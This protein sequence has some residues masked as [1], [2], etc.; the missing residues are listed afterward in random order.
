MLSG[1]FVE[2]SRRTLGQPSAEGFDRSADV[3]HKLR[4]ATHQ[5]LAGADDGQMSLGVYAPVLEWVEQL[6]IK[7][8]QASQVLGVDLI[9]FALV[10]VDEPRLARIGHQDLVATLLQHPACPRRVG[11]G[12]DCYTHGLL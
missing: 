12:L 4:A 3:V 10:G 6:R 7:T 11:P 9:R 8:C 1:S 2:A 5:R